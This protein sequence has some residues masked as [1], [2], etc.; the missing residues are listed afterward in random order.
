MV[1]IPRLTADRCRANITSKQSKLPP[2]NFTTHPPAWFEQGLPNWQPGGAIRHLPALPLPV[3]TVTRT[4]PS[5][6]A[7][8][9]S[10]PCLP[11]ASASTPPI[12]HL[13][14]DEHHSRRESPPDPKNHQSERLTSPRS[15]VRANHAQTQ[16][17]RTFQHV[18]KIKKTTYC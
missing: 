17:V 15:A 3:E 14:H 4:C 2:C 16:K 8:P 1:G 9:R 11:Q 18:I 12:P 6:H 7:P 5:R 10:P 13:L